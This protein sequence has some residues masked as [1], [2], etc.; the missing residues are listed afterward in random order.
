MECPTACSVEGINA[1]IA[2]NRRQVGTSVLPCSLLGVQP[3]HSGPCIYTGPFGA[4]GFPGGSV[5]K[6]LLA[7]AGDTGNSGSVSG[8]E[9][10]WRSKWQPTPVFL[11][12]SCHGQRS[13]AGYSPWR[14]KRSD[15]TSRLSTSTLGFA[16]RDGG[17]VS[18][19]GPTLP[20][21]HLPCSRPSLLSM[22][23]HHLSEPHSF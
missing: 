14:G 11:P 13:P 2:R 17:K 3:S 9:D 5:V 22:P 10:S 15:A 6:N 23:T 12:G 20:F 19:G 7:N 21:T 18:S 8:Q 4:W 1:H 16:S